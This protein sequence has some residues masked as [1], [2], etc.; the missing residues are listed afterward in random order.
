MKFKLFTFVYFVSICYGICQTKDTIV[1]NNSFN[2]VKVFT[3]TG[4]TLTGKMVSYSQDYLIIQDLNTL[5]HIKIPSNR[6]EKIEANE[7]SFVVSSGYDQV[8]V[9]VEENE[10]YLNSGQYILTTSAY[11][12]EQNEL[13]LKNNPTSIQYGLNNNF[14]IGVGSIFAT[15]LGQAFSFYT[16][17]KYSFKV[18]ELLRVKAGV[19][20]LVIFSAEIDQPQ[21]AILLNTG[22]TVGV[23]KAHLTASVY[24]GSLTEV[25]DFGLLGSISGMANITKHFS[26]VT[27]SFL[28]PNKDNENSQVGYLS[29]IG[30]RIHAEN[31]S[32]DFGYLTSTEINEYI[33][34]IGIPFLAF[35]TRLR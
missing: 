17:A 1:T 19:D 7:Q 6:I 10:Y 20:A 28:F 2:F 3:K 5:E 9:V 21:S 22:L 18:N 11:N 4:T 16:N 30:G 13:I 27:E 31:F 33:P 15:L 26:L 25:D 29:L 14:S 24:Y 35:S 12:L 34:I 8:Q 23:S 32:V